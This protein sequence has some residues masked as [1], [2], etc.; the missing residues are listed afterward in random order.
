MTSEY[1]FITSSRGSRKTTDVFGKPT[2]T[3][4]TTEVL[5]CKGWRKKSCV[6][7]GRQV[8]LEDG[9]IVHDQGTHVQAVSAAKK[10]LLRTFLQY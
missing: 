2:G 5:L 6:V 9:L 7:I 8:I 1:E 4:R 10:Y 3:I